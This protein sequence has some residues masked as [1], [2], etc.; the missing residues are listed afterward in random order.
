MNDELSIASKPSREER[1]LEHL[2]GIAFAASV[3]GPASLFLGAALTL[4][5]QT[6]TFLKTG[7]WPWWS[8][9]TLLEGTLP[10]FFMTWMQDDWYGFQKIIQWIIVS[11]PV[12]SLMFLLGYLSFRGG[13]KVGTKLE[14]RIRAL[15]N[16][17]MPVSEELW[18][19]FP[20]G[21]KDQR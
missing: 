6:L 9:S 14:K 2:S 3:V 10:R 20:M 8:L 19:Q 17:R 7:V 21:Q 11:C 5:L 15:K 12:S 4:L 16:S 1:I 18:K 13:T